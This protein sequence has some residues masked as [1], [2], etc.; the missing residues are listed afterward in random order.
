MLSNV[1]YLNS[2][3]IAGYVTLLTDRLIVYG[4]N[5][6]ECEEIHN[7]FLGWKSE[8]DELGV[9]GIDHIN[10]NIMKCLDLIPGD[11]G[12][13]VL[14]VIDKPKFDKLVE[15]I[16]SIEKVL[17]NEPYPIKLKIEYNDE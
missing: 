7:K 16:E 1:K 8:M 5:G 3:L 4:K 10:E 12:V 14:T 17:E 2:D 13:M 15:L 9:E 6:E 11:I